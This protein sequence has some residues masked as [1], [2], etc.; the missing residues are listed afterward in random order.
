[1][2]IQD[3]RITH[4]LTTNPTP[5]IILDILAVGHILDGG[6][7]KVNTATTTT[8]VGVTIGQITITKAIEIIITEATSVDTIINTKGA[9]N[10]KATGVVT[11]GGK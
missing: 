8:S 1:M 2:T 10:T 4:T 11:G 6:I 3:S 5:T 7:T 9:I